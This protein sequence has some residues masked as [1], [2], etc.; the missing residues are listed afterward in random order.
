MCCVCQLFFI[1]SS[2]EP[3]PSHNTRVDVELFTPDDVAMG[4]AL[5]CWLSAGVSALTR[6]PVHPRSDTG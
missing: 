1:A 5:L 2:L 3:A 6:L 4:T